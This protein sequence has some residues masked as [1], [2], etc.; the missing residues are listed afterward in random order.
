MIS[1]AVSTILNERVSS[2]N[3]RFSVGMKPSRKM[4][5]PSDVER[6]AGRSSNE[7]T[8]A[9]RVRHRDDTIHR[10]LAVETANEVRE[11]V[12]YGQVV[13][14]GDDIVVGRE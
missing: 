8:F 12:E 10:G 4:L 2:R 5:M 1:S 7:H 6:R 13:L 11:V 14:D 9:N 3:R